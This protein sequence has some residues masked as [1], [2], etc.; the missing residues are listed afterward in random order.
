MNPAGQ[1]R[2]LHRASGDPARVRRLGP[3]AIET[4][5]DPA[6]EGA[7]TCYRVTIAPNER[8]RVS[9]HRI[10]EEFYFVLSGRGTAVLDGREQTLAPGDLLRLPPGTTHG[11]VTAAEPLELLNIHAPGCRPDHDVY[12]ADGAPPPGFG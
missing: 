2:L 12:F 8:T 7:A 3:Y 1:L 10:A 4:L 9:Y 6:E 11:F 5:I